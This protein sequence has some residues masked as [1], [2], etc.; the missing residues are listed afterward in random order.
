MRQIRTEKQVQHRDRDQIQDRNQVVQM[1]AI[2]QTVRRPKG[3]QIQQVMTDLWPKIL[4]FE[5]FD[6]IWTL[7][8]QI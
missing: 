1:A 4:Q 7:N 5:H 2:N 6:P 8:K 3:V